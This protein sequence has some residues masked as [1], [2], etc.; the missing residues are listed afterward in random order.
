VRA[1]SNPYRVTNKAR[2]AEWFLLTVAAMLCGLGSHAQAQSPEVPPAESTAGCSVK[3]TNPDVSLTY[4]LAFSGHARAGEGYECPFIQ[5]LIFQLEATEAGWEIAIHE[6]SRDENLAR[7]TQPVD[8]RSG[9]LIAGSDF[10]GETNPG[11]NP[12]GATPPSARRFSF[13]SGQDSGSLAVSNIKLDARPSGTKA[14]IAEMWFDV[15]LEIQAIDGVPVYGPPVVG[16]NGRGTPP[17]ATYAPSPEY[18]KEAKKAKYQ[19]TVALSLIVD[20]QGHPRNIKAATPLGMGLAEKAIEA[21]TKWRFKPAT[22]DGKPVPA[23][24]NVVVTFHLRR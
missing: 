8:G 10:A 14:T 9:L 22:K 1:L 20:A 24:V 15:S 6:S 21:V 5:G 4:D 19:G 11:A 17:E 3:R 16:V 23:F 18:S 2:L 13:F 12:R 7:P